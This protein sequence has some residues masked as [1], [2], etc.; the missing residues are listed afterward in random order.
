MQDPQENLDTIITNAASRFWR[1]RAEYAASWLEKNPDASVEERDMAFSYEVAARQNSY[2][3]GGIRKD[4]R[5]DSRD[6]LQRRFEETQ[7]PVYLWRALSQLLQNL[8]PGDRSPR[9]PA[10]CVAPLRSIAGRIATLG[11]PGM[12]EAT[13]ASISMVLG[14]TKQGRNAFVMAERQQT[15]E[16]EAEWA[17]TLHAEGLPLDRARAVAS[18]YRSR[19]PDTLRRRTKAKT[20]SGSK[21]RSNK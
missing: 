19:N 15:L 5:I 3:A 8:E 6:D 20:P 18:G 12:P 14:F 4:P 17:A 9:L 7:N 2:S 11:L 21:P 1:R 16:D 10:W 13:P